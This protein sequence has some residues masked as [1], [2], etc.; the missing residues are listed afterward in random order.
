VQGTEVQKLLAGRTLT[1][2]GADK[3]PNNLEMFERFNK[4]IAAGGQEV[5]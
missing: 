1:E 4:L 3:V 2:F 5:K